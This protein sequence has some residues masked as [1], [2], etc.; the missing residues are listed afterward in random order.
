MA[1]LDKDGI[2]AKVTCAALLERDGW[3][4][5]LR[6]STPKAV[7]YRRGDGEIVIVIHQGRGWFD[8]TSP[9]KG[10]VFTLAQHLGATDF[11]T[12]LKAVS[13]LVGFEPTAPIWQRKSRP[14]PA[15]A[16]AKR[17]SERPQMAPGSSA[18]IYLAHTRAVP[19]SII[20]AASAG[21][22]LREGPKGSI[23]AAHIDDRGKVI[24]WEERG[25]S[26]R[27]F[28]SGGAKALFVLGDEENAK[29]VCVTEAA[30]DAMSLAALEGCR[31]D[32]LYVSTGGGWAP[33]TE[34][35]I[36]ALASR[37]GS[38]LIAA[39]DANDQGDAYAAR[40]RTIAASEGAAFLRLWPD[41]LDWNE[42]IN[43]AAN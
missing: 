38:Q 23:W 41:A 25:A 22:R 16:I 10:D 40:L 27:G 21:D 37:P 30:I 15:T 7:K 42:Q 35:R 12:A 39:S 28:A 29:R 43:R 5:D 1:E 33:A 20:A 26:W 9:A 17:W 14:H 32:S 8:P 4:V 34:A 19:A 3:K 2:K 31:R 18:W 13:E 36:R 6:E 24:G 11:S